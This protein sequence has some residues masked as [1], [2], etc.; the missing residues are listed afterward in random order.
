MRLKTLNGAPLSQNLNFDEDTLLPLSQCKF[1][2]ASLETMISSSDETAFK[3]RRLGSKD[4]RLH[5][6]WSQPYLPDS[7]G[8]LAEMDVSVSMPHVGQSSSFPELESTR[9][10]TTMD[11]DEPSSAP[12]TFLQH[13][14][15][16][17]DTMLS[18]QV[19]QDIAGGD[20]TISSSSFLTT[21]F[22]TTISELGGE[23]NVEE[24]TLILQVP[25]KMSLSSLNSLPTAQRLRTIYPQTPTPNVLC[26]LMTHPERREV[27]VRKGGYTMDLY[28]ITVADDT[29]AGFKVSFWL[30]PP[31]EHKMMAQPL[32]K[33]LESIKVGNILL[34]RNIALTA[35]RD[36]V[37]GQSLNPSIA[38]ARTTI[39]VLMDSSGSH[40]GHLGRLPV[41]MVETFMKVKRW[42]RTHVAPSVVGG[43]KRRKMSDGGRE[44]KRKP[45]NSFLDESL[46]PDTMPL[47]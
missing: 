41:S 20:E 17:H 7:G 43:K 47:A 15:V 39:D 35:F 10:D 8:R 34:L 14:F 37:Y 1:M 40:V 16:L 38:R 27:F 36:T 42:A 6:G 33:T 31:N 22:S 32:L 23:G 21:S 9:L 2:L 5:T 45:S 44:A 19:A 46:P 26:V 13:S 18:S 24:Q 28:E 29:R 3:W 25:L 4:T 12:D 30:R 11:F